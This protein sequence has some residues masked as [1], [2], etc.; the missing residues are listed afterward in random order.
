MRIAKIASE[1]GVF[2]G[3]EPLD[4]AARTEE[5][6]RMLAGEQVTPEARAAAVALMEG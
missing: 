4:A 3:T 1:D 2:S 5:I 6:A